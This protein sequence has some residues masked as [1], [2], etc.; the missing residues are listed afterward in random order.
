MSENNTE[1]NEVTINLAGVFV[2]AILSVALV[3]SIATG[4]LQFASLNAVLLTVLA[5][6]NHATNR[7]YG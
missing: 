2:G 1:R 6:A 4:E 7:I 3:W 5:I